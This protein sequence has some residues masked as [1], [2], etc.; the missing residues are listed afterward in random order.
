MFQEDHTLRLINY[1]HKLYVPA[2]KTVKVKFGVVLVVKQR[3]LLKLY[4]GV[5]I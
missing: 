5:D 1:H 3:F 4:K 2:G